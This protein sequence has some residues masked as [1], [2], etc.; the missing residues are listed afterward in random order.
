MFERPSAVNDPVAQQMLQP[1]QGSVEQAVLPTTSS[2]TSSSQARLVQLQE[3][4]RAVAMRPKVLLRKYDTGTNVSNNSTVNLV[5]FG[6]N[7]LVLYSS[8]GLLVF[9]CCPTLHFHVYVFSRYSGA[10]FKLR[11]WST[12]SV[13]YS[14]GLATLQFF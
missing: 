4:P 1:L 6:Y 10:G 3:Q 5:V 14:F 11:P 7:V 12:W 8:W 9:F 13:I 2:T